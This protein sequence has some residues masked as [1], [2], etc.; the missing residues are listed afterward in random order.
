MNILV[1]IRI[2]IR[3][4]MS[5]TNGS[6]PGYETGSKSLTFKMPTKTVIRIRTNMSLIH[7]TLYHFLSFKKNSTQLTEFFIDMYCTVQDTGIRCGQESLTFSYLII[8]L[9]SYQCCGSG[10][11]SGSTPKCHGFAT[12]TCIVPCGIHRIGSRVTLYFFCWRV[13][14]LRLD[15]HPKNLEEREVGHR[16]AVQWKTQE[17]TETEK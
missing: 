2:W 9:Y 13:S 16:R 1:Y 14:G 15:L 5:L 8:I 12:R 3:G 17:W 10:F 11:E 6:G 4:S 7:N